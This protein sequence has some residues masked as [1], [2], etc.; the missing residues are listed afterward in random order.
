[1][2]YLILIS[3][4]EDFFLK[5]AT[6]V[7]RG[8]GRAGPCRAVCFVCRRWCVCVALA[9]SLL[10]LLACRQGK[11]TTPHH[12]TCRDVT[13]HLIL[14]VR[15][16]LK[17]CRCVWTGIGVET[18]GFP[19]AHDNPITTLFTCCPCMEYDPKWLLPFSTAKCYLRPGASILRVA[20]ITTHSGLWYV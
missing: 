2:L 12:V 6:T 7:G 8:R 17:L 19:P 5:L 14:G 11:L 4:G 18:C 16:V 10:T 9:L 15:S 13:L 20:G 3:G 1:M